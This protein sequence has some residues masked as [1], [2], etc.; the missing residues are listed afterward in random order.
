M[1][2]SV[3]L[4][5]IPILLLWFS[6]ALWAEKTDIVYL[7]NGDRITGEVKSLLR[8]KLEFSTDHMGTVFID[9]DDIREIISDTGQVVE[10]SNEQ[11]FY[12]P[13]HKP[14]ESD[15]VTIETD[16][17]PVGVD[18]M[19]VVSM[20]PVESGFWD[21][22]DLSASLGFT[23]DKS[24]EVGK[25]NLNID[26]KYRRPD[27]VTHA[28]M[29]TEVTTQEGRDNTSRAVFSATHLAYKKNRRFLTYFGNLE[30]NDELGLDLRA[31]LGAGYGWVPIR[32][33]RQWL[34]LAVGLDVNREIPNMGDP[35]NNLESVA[36]VRYEYFRYN[37]PERTFDASLMIFPGL[38]DWGRVRA[39]FDTSFSLEFVADLFWKLSFYTSYDNKPISDE[40][41]TIDYGITS[42]IGYKF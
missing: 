24:S 6:T 39:S 41:S 33:Q 40:A 1:R 31:L 5:T 21:R 9:W 15:M 3:L 18:Y 7:K 32:S 20:Y 22:L 19:D 35:Q 42:S 23:W 2:R 10:L 28:S 16:R 34:N 26:A 36:M 4:G 37:G 17:G 13:L 29:T 38:T 14:E 27:S 12:G 30:H 8:G 25:Y 11:R